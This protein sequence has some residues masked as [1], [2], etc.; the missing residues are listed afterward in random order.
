MK[1]FTCSINKSWKLKFLVVL[2][3]ICGLCYGKKIHKCF[4]GA[5][6]SVQVEAHCFHG[7]ISLD[8]MVFSITKFKKDLC[9]P[10][11]YYLD[12]N[13]K[14]KK[15]DCCTHKIYSQKCTLDSSIDAQWNASCETRKHCNPSIT[16]IDLSDH[17]E[18]QVN[19]ECSS[20]NCKSQW[21]DIT[22][23][24]VQGMKLKL[25]V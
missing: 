7:T 18:S 16:K 21:L 14:S 25:L 20:T 3:I 15:C 13:G 6:N 24:C 5:N 12:S 4:T 19:Y 9:N 22:Y 1:G 17:C 10:D 23:Y 11:C 8:K 2:L